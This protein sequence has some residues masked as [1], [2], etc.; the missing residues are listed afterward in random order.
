MAVM[1]VAGALIS[2]CTPTCSATR[3]V[4]RNH[5][6]HPQSPRNKRALPHQVYPFCV[7]GP[8]R[9]HRVP[10]LPGQSC[11]RFTTG[12]H[13][14]AGRSTYAH[15]HGEQG[16][17]VLRAPRACLTGLGVSPLSR[18]EVQGQVGGQVRVSQGQAL[19]QQA[20]QGHR[21]L[22]TVT[23]PVNRH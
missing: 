8:N 22:L 15:V 3:P 14:P 5:L 18:R 11:S 13:S 16:D 4:L 10:R 20:R 2:S 23:Q 6:W 1:A 9:G 19:L 17:G 21:A 7:G 12:R